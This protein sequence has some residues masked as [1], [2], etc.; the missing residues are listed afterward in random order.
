MSRPSRDRD[1]V[2]TS[3]TYARTP[4]SLLILRHRISGLD[5]GFVVPA[6]LM[7]GVTLGA[8]GLG[9][10]LDEGE[11]DPVGLCE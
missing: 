5:A 11:D 10:V 3:K 4:G 6:A 9:P 2:T 8:A 7:S 1:Q